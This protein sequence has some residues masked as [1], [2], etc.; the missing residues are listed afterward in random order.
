MDSGLQGTN[1]KVQQYGFK[2][3]KAIAIQVPVFPF[4][5]IK[6]R[7]SRTRPLLQFTFPGSYSVP[8]SQRQK[9]EKDVLMPCGVNNFIAKL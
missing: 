2:E 4:F 7:T 3:V 9:A 8:N 5:S 6:I 1:S